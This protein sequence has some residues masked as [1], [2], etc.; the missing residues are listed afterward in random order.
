MLRV[1]SAL[2]TLVVSLLLV[3]VSLIALAC[4]QCC[5]TI[6][7]FNFEN[8]G[9]AG[10]YCRSATD[11]EKIALILTEYDLVALQE[12]M[13]ASN[14][15]QRYCYQC[16]GTTCHLE[17]LVNCMRSLTSQ[18]WKYVCVETPRYGNR[19]EYY[20]ILYNPAILTYLGPVENVNI[21]GPKQAP[22]AEF[23]VRPPMYAYFRA[24]NFDFI[25][26]NYHAPSKGAENEVPLLKQALTAARGR[27][28]V[29]E[30]D[31]ILLGDFN[32]REPERFLPLEMRRL[33]TD[34][35]TRGSEPFDTIFID[36]RYTSHEYTGCAGIDRR[37]I[38]FSL[39]NHAIVWARFWVCLED[40]D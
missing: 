38:A 15:A 37:P 7:S 2:S 18:D 21:C 29:T 22:L 30:R 40:D 3:T 28:S 17:L 34:A 4:Q 14:A 6:A 36:V 35:T 1:R 26:I 11:L 13:R 39:S 25:V 9:Y 8:F 27:V 20:V 32:L 31:V 33:V 16:Q 12:V 19:Y 10:K 5:I 24:G 23:K